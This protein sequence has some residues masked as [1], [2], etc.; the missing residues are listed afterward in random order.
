VNWFEIV[1][2]G[3]TILAA[4]ITAVAT[5]FLW[6]VT[7]VLAAETKRLAEATS[8]PQVVAQLLPS[9]WSLIH[10]DFVVQNTGTGTA[11]YIEVN[12][13][14]PLEHKGSTSSEIQV[15][16]HRISILKAGQ[17]LR[18]YIGNFHPHIDKVYNV[19][20]S[21]LRSPTDIRRESIT[22]TLDMTM[23][24]NVSQ[25]GASDPVVQIAEEVKKMRE[26]W[27]AVASGF[28]AIEVDVHTTL[29]RAKQER[30]LRKR[31]RQ[32]EKQ[33]AVAPQPEVDSAGDAGGDT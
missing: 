12:F 29:D 9:P 23:F 4:V 7:R 31:W 14:P 25:L 24:K 11:F 16:L 10:A 28:R 20:I 15:P 13:D 33:Q 1:Q 18:S 3:V 30:E 32:Q 6:R 17:S 2:S 5:V 19:T 8:Q 26:D 22:Y 21:W 27:R